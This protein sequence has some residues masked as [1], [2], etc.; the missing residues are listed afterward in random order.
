[1]KDPIV[2]Q[3]RR[4]RDAHARR[5]GFDIHAICEDIRK[6]EVASGHPLVR[7]R[8]RKFPKRPP[9]SRRS[10]AQTLAEKAAGHD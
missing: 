4:V 8:P 10:E 1:M 5:F 7:L 2:T 6:V 9:G 3:V